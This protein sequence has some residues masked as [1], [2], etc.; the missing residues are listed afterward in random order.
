MLP[1]DQIPGCW[2]GSKGTLGMGKR[3][4]EE[5]DMRIHHPSFLLYLDDVRE[6]EEWGIGVLGQEE[7]RHHQRKKRTL[8]R[9]ELPSASVFCMGQAFLGFLEFQV[10]ETEIQKHVSSTNS[11]LL[12]IRFLGKLRWYCW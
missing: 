5:K 7:Q 4:E 3:G 11:G 10:L 6:W 12:K 1:I 9:A 2:H 8:D